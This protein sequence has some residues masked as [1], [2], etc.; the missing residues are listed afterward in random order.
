MSRAVIHINSDKR[1]RIDYQALEDIDAIFP[2]EEE[3]VVEF[4]SPYLT[5]I[6]QPPGITVSGALKKTFR[7]KYH[8]H[9][10]ELFSTSNIQQKLD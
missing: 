8:Q 10:T 4:I 1:R 5:S 3:L 9:V 7:E 2:D 6:Y